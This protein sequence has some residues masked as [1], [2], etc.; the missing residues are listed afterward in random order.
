MVQVWRDLGPKS[1]KKPAPPHF[2]CQ[3]NL[4]LSLSLS[5]SIPWPLATNIVTT[6]LNTS[7]SIVGS[8]P[9]TSLSSTTC[10]LPSLAT[11]IGHH[12]LHRSLLSHRPNLLVIAKLPPHQVIPSFFPSSSS[13]FRPASTVLQ[14]EQ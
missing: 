3:Q 1:M 2:Y 7:I 4:S 9:T 13:S 8:C 14:S 5:L 6:I 11:N 10:L 12:S